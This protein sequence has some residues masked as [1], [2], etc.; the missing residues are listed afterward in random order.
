[1]AVHFL[2]LRLKWSSKTDPAPRAI[3][4]L[5]VHGQPIIT[6]ERVD[7]RSLQPFNHACHDKLTQRQQSTTASGAR[8]TERVIHNSALLSV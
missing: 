5:T 2:G 8:N 3:A 4:N 7:A 1:M 6:Q